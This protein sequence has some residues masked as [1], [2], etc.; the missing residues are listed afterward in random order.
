[1]ILITGAAGFIGS[2]VVAA[3]NERGR[4]DLIVCDWLGQDERW[5]NLRKRWFQEFVFPSDLME[6]L[7]DGGARVDAVIHMGANSSTTARDG[8]EIIRSNLQPSLRLLDWCA[9]HSI[10][11]VY[12]SSAAT[13]GDKAQG[14]EDG[15]DLRALRQLRPLNLYGWSKHQ[16]DLIVAERVEKRL[17]LP[18]KCIGLKFFNVFGQNE[19]HKSDMMSVVA[20]N[21]RAA[22]EGSEIKLFK[23]H[24]KEFADGGQLRDFI[25]VNDVVDVILWCL[26]AA[27]A[28]GLYN[29]GTGRATSFRELIEALYAAVAREPRIS[30]VPMPEALRDRYQYYT[31]ASL[32]S[33][34]DA[35]Y[36]NQFTPITT[37]VAE[38]VTYLSRDDPYR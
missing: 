18:P 7:Q 23:S 28:Y 15:I 10:P 36:V 32:A 19:Y 24:R 13:Y 20:K 3:L 37:A 34:R 1:M 17:P 33:L 5:Q 21:Y 31:Q 9:A 6:F 25:Y 2:N 14:F 4:G 38:Y 30:Y 12:A 11:L 22:A 8:D 27:P 26:E 16:F 35:G 29:V